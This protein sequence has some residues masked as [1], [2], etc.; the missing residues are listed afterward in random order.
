MAQ[1]SNTS[2]RALVRGAERALDQFKYE[3]A[4]EIGLQGIEDG[5]WGDVPSAQCGAVGGHMVRKM[6][7]MAEQ[8]MAGRTR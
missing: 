1:G 2:N 7:E 4:R 6:I 5:Y 8:Q 3:V